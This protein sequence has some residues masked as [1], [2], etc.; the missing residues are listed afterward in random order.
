MLT[1]YSRIM[2]QKVVSEAKGRIC[3]FW[4]AFDASG[5]GK[6]RATC[7]TDGERD[8][9]MSSNLAPVVRSVSRKRRERSIVFLPLL[10]GCQNTLYE[11]N[12][13]ERN[14]L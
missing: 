8:V 5:S 9:V 4:S 6:S 12:K 10:E 3:L 2:R 13:E 7:M 11:V 1:S 14:S